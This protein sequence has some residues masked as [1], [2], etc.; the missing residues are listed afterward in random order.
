VVYLNF[1]DRSG[2][3]PIPSGIQNGRGVEGVVGRRKRE[4]VGWCGRRREERSVFT[5]KISVALLIGLGN[6]YQVTTII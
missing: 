4:K 3:G 5:L 6:H 2:L 1:N